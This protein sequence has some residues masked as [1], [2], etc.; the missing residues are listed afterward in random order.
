MDEYMT[1]TRDFSRKFKREERMRTNANKWKI[2]TAK[3]GK[4]QKRKLRK[5]GMKKKDQKQNLD[6]DKIRNT[7]KE[8]REKE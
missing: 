5:K 4:I 3:K 6:R 1:R 2:F 8:D 7:N